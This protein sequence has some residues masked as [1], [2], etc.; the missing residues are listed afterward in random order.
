MPSVEVEDHRHFHRELTDLK[1]QR[2]Q[3]TNR[4]KGYLANQGICLDGD[5]DFPEIVEQQHLW[6]G[7]T[8]PHGLRARLLCEYQRRCGKGSVATAVTMHWSSRRRRS[9]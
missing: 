4:I 7:E 9:R 5:D 1:E 8:L 3:H 2:T 6:N